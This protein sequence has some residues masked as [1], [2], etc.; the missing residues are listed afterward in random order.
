MGETVIGET[1]HGRN[2]SVQGRLSAM[3]IFKLLYK[4]FAI[5]AGVISARLGRSIFRSLWS[6]I[7]S[8]E[9]PEATTA[10]ASTGKVVGAAALEAATMAATAAAVNRAT[11]KSFHHLV[12]IWPGERKQES[13]DEQEAR[14]G[15]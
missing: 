12:G 5:I 9:P 1:G 15:G 14:A 7:D 2:G 11:A 8:E 10:E 4:P 3:K 13:D 6:K